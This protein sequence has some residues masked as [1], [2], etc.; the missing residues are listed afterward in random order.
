MLRGLAGEADLDDNGEITAAEL[1]KYVTDHVRQT[2]IALD[3]EQTLQMLGENV[4][5]IL[6][7]Y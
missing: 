6:A 3:R 1:H 2:A 7:K 5:G 4:S